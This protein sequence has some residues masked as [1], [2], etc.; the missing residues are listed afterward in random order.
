MD[1]F[2]FQQNSTVY[3]DLA[4]IQPFQWSFQP[5]VSHLLVE[6]TGPSILSEVA[7]LP[8]FRWIS[9]KIVKTRLFIQIYPLSNTYNAKNN[10][11]VS[12]LL[13]EDPGPSITSVVA[14]LPDF[15]GFPPILSKL[16]YLYRCSHHSTPR[17]PKLTLCLRPAR[18]GPREADSQ[19]SG[20][21]ARF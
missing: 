16:N 15:D 10:I 1:F 8:D 21:I 4:A 13:A 3:T 14:I 5:F 19:C 7:I 6:D 2:K 20:N 9:S 12:P 11:F 17:M 18:W